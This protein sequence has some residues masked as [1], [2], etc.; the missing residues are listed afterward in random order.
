MLGLDI[1]CNH[2]IL[3]G[4]RCGRTAIPAASHSNKDVRESFTATHSPHNIKKTVKRLQ[5]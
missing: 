1:S 2:P 4:Y 5:Q 3:S